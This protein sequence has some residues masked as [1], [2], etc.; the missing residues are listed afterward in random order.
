METKY[1][2]RLLEAFPKTF[3]LVDNPKDPIH[4]LMDIAGFM[5]ESME[6]DKNKAASNLF[7]D[8]VDIKMPYFSYYIEFES[9]DIVDKIVII[10]DASGHARICTTDRQFM[11]NNITGFEHGEDIIP[12]GLPAGSSILGISYGLDWDAPAHYIT[13]SGES[14][15]YEYGNDLGE[16]PTS[17]DYSVVTQSYDSLGVDEYLSIV[18]EQITGDDILPSGVSVGDYAKVAYLTQEPVGGEIKVIDI[19]NLQNPYYEDSDGIVVK[20]TDYTVN[21]N[22]VIFANGRSDYNPAIEI[23]LGDGLYK[24]EYPVN[25]QPDTGFNSQ[26]I[27][28]YDYQLDDPRYLDQERKLHDVGLKGK[29]YVSY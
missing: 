7:I 27:V 6:I 20:S 8:Q 18:E 17:G 23:D 26:Y 29:P 25:W 14:Y 9:A 2:K 16:I 15:I 3:K 28:E 24:L 19:Y 22:K 13:V 4:K 5:L 1:T 10:P 11:E 21:G 12:S